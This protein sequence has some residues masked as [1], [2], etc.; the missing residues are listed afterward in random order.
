MFLDDFDH[1]RQ[2]GEARLLLD[3]ILDLP[4]PLLTLDLIQIRKETLD[5]WR[6]TFKNGET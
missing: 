2:L 1:P 4:R 6:E 3:E 5:L